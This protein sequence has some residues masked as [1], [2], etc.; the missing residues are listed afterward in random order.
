MTLLADRVKQAR[1]SAGLSQAD[2]ARLSGISTAAMS[3]IETGQTKTLK[4]STATAFAKAT[5]YT[6]EWLTSGR[7]QERSLK[8]SDEQINFILR[9]LEQ[10]A[11]EHRKLVEDQV[12]ALVGVQ[13]QQ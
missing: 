8:N 2:L 7:G 1:E 11:P 9:G 5:G 4:A 10:L 6:A 13:G 12:R 3:Q